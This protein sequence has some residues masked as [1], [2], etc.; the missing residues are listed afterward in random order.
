MLGKFLPAKAR[1]ELLGRKLSA[2]LNSCMS[3]VFVSFDSNRLGLIAK[4]VR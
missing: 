3:H 4:D 2:L 1:G